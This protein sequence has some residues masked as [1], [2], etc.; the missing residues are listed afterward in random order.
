MKKKNPQF[1]KRIF[2]ILKKKKGKWDANVSSQTKHHNSENCANVFFFK[3]SNEKFA[4]IYGNENFR[5]KFC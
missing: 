1:N 5:N 2:A 3:F 4:P